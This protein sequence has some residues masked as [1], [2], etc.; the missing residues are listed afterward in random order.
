MYISKKIE[1]MIN[2]AKCALCQSGMKYR[3]GAC[4][5]YKGKVCST[6]FN[7]TSRSVLHRRIFPSVHAEMDAVCN[8]INKTNNRLTYSKGKEPKV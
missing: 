8:F 3:L 5:L 7:N 6:G 4:V 1:K 2:I